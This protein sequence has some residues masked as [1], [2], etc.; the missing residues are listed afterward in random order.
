MTKTIFFFLTPLVTIALFWYN[1]PI[2][3]D[4]EIIVSD[5]Y[6]SNYHDIGY[7]DGHHVWTGYIDQRYDRDFETGEWKLHDY[8]F[9]IMPMVLADT[10]G[11][12]NAGY[13]GMADQSGIGAGSTCTGGVYTKS[14]AIS[15]V[16][17]QDTSAGG[18]CELGYW[19]WD[20]SS[21]S[22]YSTITDSDFRIDI[23]TA[24]NPRNCDLVKMTY[25]PSLASN[26][27]QTL[28]D[29]V[30]GNISNT[31]F[32]TDST[33]CI[34][35]VNDVLVDLGSTADSDIQTQVSGAFAWWAMGVK[36][37]V[38]TRGSVTHSQVF[39]ASAPA[40]HAQL[41]ITYTAG[42][43]PTVP[44]QVTGLTATPVG[45]TEIDLSWSTPASGGS[46][47]TG[48]HI[49][50]QNPT[51]QSYSDLVADT[52]GT[53]TTLSHLGLLLG[54]SYTYK[55]A[56]INAIGQGAYSDPATAVV[57]A[58]GCDS[59]ITDLHFTSL[60]NTTI[61]LAWTAPS[62]GAQTITGYQIN[63]TT[64]AGIPLTVSTN[65]TANTNTT[66]T[67]SPLTYN[68]YYSF[69]VQPWTIA[70]C[71]SPADG[72]IITALI[73]PSVTP[74][75][76]P[77]DLTTANN[78]NTAACHFVRTDINSTSLLLNVT[79]P[80]VYNPAI[81]FHYKYART[82]NTYTGFADVPQA[83]NRT[84][85]SFQFTGVDN[86]IID[87][88]FTDQ[89]TN[90]TCKYVITQTQFELLNQIA[91]FRAGDF[92]TSGDFGIFDL[93][94]LI[95]IIISMIGL[96]RITP[97]V[98]AVFCTGIIFA[99]GYFGIITVPGEIVAALAVIVLLAYLT[100]RKGGN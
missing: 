73:N 82:N 42:S 84:M 46:A 43:P 35:V 65:N 49:Q 22:V 29:D 37:N 6:G 97:I 100:T 87:V 36:T 34:S 67:I 61:N 21:I 9:S 72:N 55:V 53:A 32:V 10:Y 27:A 79:Y 47:I 93:V 91:A 51:G 88:L 64:P 45:T 92:G 90:A 58:I 70:A 4:S 11:Y 86:E 60:T 38:M 1:I 31:N 99:M 18:F 17:V 81:N 56:A 57:G 23:S 94:T 66:A 74:G 50:Y 68:L 7:K 30:I 95:V 44:A 2:I 89:N 62:P 16:F 96:N 75:S 52:G 80:D 63:Y 59:P 69:R 39:G 98:G 54:T 26:G 85:S 24:S 76:L 19:E 3:P 33:F 8:D 14:T 15:P 40:T 5:M 41:Q 28:W 71:H 12:T 77:T 78:T 13:A 25:Q 83:N 48:Y 20:V